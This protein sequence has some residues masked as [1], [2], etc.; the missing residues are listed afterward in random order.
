MKKFLQLVTFFLFAISFGQ[1]IS[2]YQNILI[3]T[4]FADAKAN[5]FGLGD[6]LAKK[7]VAKKY[8]VIHENADYNCGILKADLRDNSNM[9][10]NKI[11]VDFKDCNG[12][13]IESFSGKSSIKDFEPGMRDAL[14]NALKNLSFSNP[15]EQTK[16]VQTQNS[17]PAVSIPVVTKT[18]NTAQPIFSENKTTPTTN[19]PVSKAEVFSNGSLNLNKINISANQFIL[20]NPN[21]SVPYAIFKASSKKDVFHVQLENGTSTI[22]YFED[23]KIVIDLPNSDGTF[24]KEVLSRK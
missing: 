5:R 21:S 17:K 9:F 20:A 7:L 6:L 4:E 14:E 24:R 12:K 13:I 16:I 19:N 18:E 1:N 10:T 22:G 3:P 2:N 8:V 23:G 11:I 15:V